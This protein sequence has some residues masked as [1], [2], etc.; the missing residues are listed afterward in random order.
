MSKI[1]YDVEQINHI[2]DR[3][4]DNMVR[5][6][7]ATDRIWWLKKWHKVPEEVANALI[8]KCTLVLEKNWYGDEPCA[9][10]IEKYLKEAKKS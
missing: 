9:A 5:I 7:W 3:E 2:L 1:S 10:V 8:E 4:Y 6:G